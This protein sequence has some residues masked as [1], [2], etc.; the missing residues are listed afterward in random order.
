M[1]K[2]FLC[3]AC[4]LSHHTYI[5][6]T[7][8][9]HCRKRV[10]PI[11]CTVPVFKHSFDVKVL[12]SVKAAVVAHFSETGRRSVLC[13][14][15]ERTSI[16]LEQYA[17]VVAPAV[18]ERWHH[19]AGRTTNNEVVRQET[20]W[21]AWRLADCACLRPSQATADAGSLSSPTTIAAATTSS[22]SS[23]SSDRRNI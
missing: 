20:Q 14:R 12:V 4:A 11:T 10:Y 16:V 21:T 7:C 1:F 5:Y 18:N 6:A 17:V 15:G 8:K 23:G 2:F 9:R 13:N 19:V 22:C 3:A